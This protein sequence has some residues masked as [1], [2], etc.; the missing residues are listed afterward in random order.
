[1]SRKKKIL[2]TGGSGFIA[3]HVILQL[4]NEGFD[5][6]ASVRTPSRSAEIMDA[7]VAHAKDTTDLESRLVFCTLDLNEDDGWDEAL[8][9]CQALI[10]T[11]SPFPMTPPLHEDDLIK[12]AVDG[13]LRALTA[14]QAAGVER[15]ILTSSVAAIY[16]KRLAAGR[17]R[18]NETDWSESNSP[19]ATPYSRS[20]TKA[21]K[22]AWN[23]VRE[24]PEMKLTTINPSLV[25]GPPLDTKIGTSLK[26]VARLL[27]GKDPMVPNLG[28]AV[29]D[30]RDIALMHVRALQR[31]ESAGSRFIGSERF[32]WM[33]DIALLLKAEYPD[34]KIATR[35]APDWVMRLM[36][37]FD[38]TI[39]GI[40][41]SLG[42]EIPLDNSAAAEVL[43]MEFIEAR[44]A[45]KT[46]ASYLIREHLVP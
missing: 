7:M 33:Q 15:V 13:T 36:G 22:A 2:V 12:P 42:Q 8:K 14:A 35:L 4:L 46:S 17:N 10:H 3:K 9:G 21:E 26:V 31:P 18:Y 19:L 43:G 40:I 30:V 16:N 44:Q 41:P 24:Y 37:M 25:L 28:M 20:K 5:V 45:I 11:A 27:S 38:K 1:M 6:R 29:V 34:R 32:M 23:F 39:A